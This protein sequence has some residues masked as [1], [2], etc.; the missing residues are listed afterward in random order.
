ML[1]HK[2]FTS[3]LFFV[4]VF[5][6]FVVTSRYV[7]YPDE[8]INLLA[9]K[10]LLAGGL[11]YKDFWDHHLPFAWYSG[12]LLL[13]VTGQS[14]VKTRLLWALVQFGSFAMLYR[15]IA[16]RHHSLLKPFQ[17]F[18][19]I[20]PALALYF[21]FHL[22]LADSLA[23][24]FFS[25]AFW[26]LL[27]E[28]FAKTRSVKS[29]F[30][31]SLLVFCMVMS[32]AT[33]LYMA[34]VLYLWHAYLLHWK[35]SRAML[36]LI[37]WSMLPYGLFFG[38]LIVTNTWNEFY[39]ANF[40]YNTTYYI[41]I[42]NYVRGAHFNPFKFSLTLIA[43]FLDGYLPLLTQMKHLDLYLPVGTMAGLGTLSLVAVFFAK[44]W[45]LGA[46][47]FFLLALSAPRSNLQSFHETDYQSA[48]F[49]VLGL[50]SSVISLWHLY[51]HT[52]KEEWRADFQ[53]VTRFVLTLFFVFT[54]IFLIANSFQV[55][56]KL[57]TQKFPSI[58]NGGPAAQFID[59]ILNDGDYYFV[60]P[61][62]PQESFYVVKGRWTGKH[63]SLLPQFREGA[64]LRAS[65]L[66]Q[67]NQH[68]PKVVI[69]KQSASIFQTPALE[70]GKFF[71][72]WMKGSYTPLEKVKG[73]EV[74]KNPTGVD[75]KADLHIRT[76]DLPQ[77]L[78]ALK[79]NGYIQ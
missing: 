76:E 27:A 59:E 68:P 18:F 6:L 66:S 36:S 1:I 7:D 50:I 35:P 44:D 31:S 9:G 13:F 78:T 11:P 16:K 79:N 53:R 77:V 5:C 24:F 38:F 20:Y 45:I 29:L 74:L 43:N 47:F 69:Y 64:E 46:L 49:L 4:A 32:S 62:E 72:D 70:F 51:E 41:S 75:L 60:G 73:V 67:F 14:F 8:Y 30:A 21:W 61:Y 22:F 39:F 55:G 58:H 19:L 48:M 25:I 10:T 42:P 37:G 12:A 40:V 71:L 28:T 26:M 54:S 17:A 3:I 52:A 63:P 56:Y 57:Y 23:V 15:W 65:F 34:V 33:F 2:H